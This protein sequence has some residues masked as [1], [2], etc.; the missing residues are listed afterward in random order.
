MTKDECQPAI[1]VKGVYKDFILP[2][3][4]DNNLKQK[5]LHPLKRVSS[6]KQHA[7]KDITFTINKGD[8]FGIIG[9]NGSGKSTLLKIIAEIYSPTKGNVKV[10]GSLTPFIELGVGFNPELTGKENVFLNGA[11]LG[12]SKKEMLD[13]YQE[14]VDFSELEMFMDQ[15]LKN[16]SS[17]MQVR[18][19]FSVAI[20][21]KSDILLLD[22]VL[23]VGDV[24][25]QKK[26]FDYFKELKRQKKTVVFV[27]HSMGQ[28]KEYCNRAILIDNAVVVPTKDINDA[29]S[30][31]GEMMGDRQRAQKKRSPTSKNNSREHF[32][33]N[34]PTSDITK[35]DIKVSLP[36]SSTTTEEKK[37]HYAIGI[38][39]NA[40][41]A[42]LKYNSFLSK[43]EPLSIGKSNSSVNI[44]IKFINILTRGTYTVDVAL[45]DME[46]NVLQQFDDALK[47]T[48]QNNKKNVGNLY[49]VNELNISYE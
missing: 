25:F 8:F 18:L 49:A 27:T 28:V 41:Q 31:Y 24:N 22:E 37:Y 35:E 23:A 26:C 15:K 11:M 9:R 3:E 1:E 6:E 48:I 33:L 14:I 16:Y 12:F 17:G 2:H 5:L 30:E 19:A 42:A 45:L 4:V 44:D 10:H 13:M 29:L 21:A 46:G 34:R 39:D 32:K 43:S 40:L 38:K 7:L 47:F 20:R 36:L